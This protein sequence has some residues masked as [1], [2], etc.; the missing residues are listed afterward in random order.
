MPP[1]THTPNTHKHVCAQSNSGN[2]WVDVSLKT[3]TAPSICNT[4]H[5][6]L[7]PTGGMIHW[8]REVKLA[9]TIQCS[10]QRPHYSIQSS[11]CCLA[12]LSLTQLLLCTA[13]TKLQHTEAMHE[14]TSLDEGCNAYRFQLGACS[15]CICII[16]IIIILLLAYLH[17]VL[18]SF[19]HT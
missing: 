1:H 17:F 3:G 19:A 15:S 9:S 13:L 2:Q 18:V 10:F 8:E 7:D 12:V 4:A 5:K 11:T 16:V 14:S 6:S